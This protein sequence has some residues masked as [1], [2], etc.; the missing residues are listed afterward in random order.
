[1][2]RLFPPTPCSPS[3]SH[4]SFLY[5]FLLR[6]LHLAQFKGQGKVKVLAQPCFAFSSTA[7]SFQH[8]NLR[9]QQKGSAEPF[10][11]YCFGD[12]WGTLGFCSIN[13]SG[14]NSLQG[15]MRMCWELVCQSLHPTCCLS[16]RSREEGLQWYCTAVLHKH[17]HILHEK[18]KAVALFTRVQQY[19]EGSYEYQVN[20]LLIFIR[21][22]KQ[23]S[24]QVYPWPQDNLQ[25]LAQWL[26]D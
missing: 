4:P 9:I 13:C 10:F 23:R 2:V 18:M 6:S 11:P 19:P 1:M 3:C 24:W 7:Q 16:G 8:T 20:S 21:G 25:S 5:F 12:F 22:E 14:V 15:M 26:S 17:R